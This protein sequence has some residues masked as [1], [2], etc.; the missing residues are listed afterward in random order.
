MADAEITYGLSVW[1]FSVSYFG[2][3][4]P[5]IAMPIDEHVCM[6]MISRS[7]ADCNTLS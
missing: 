1:L 3:Q 4:L 7:R 6:E 5:I 2:A